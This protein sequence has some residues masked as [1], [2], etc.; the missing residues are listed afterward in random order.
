MI[1]PRDEVIRAGLG[2][3]GGRLA[4]AGASG[5]DATIVHDFS[6]CLNA[7]GPA[8]GVRRAVAESAVEE[9]PDP[10]SRAA[11]RAASA[12]WGR[13][14]EEIML[15]AGAAE[16]IYAVCGAYLRPHDT[17]VVATPAFGDYARATQLCGAT[18]RTIAAGDDDLNE[19]M[20]SVLQIRPRLLFVATPMN[21]TGATFGVETVARLA[22]A[23]RRCD[24]LLV[25][26]QAYDA[27]T[28]QPLGTPAL[29][30]HPNVLH[31]RSLT[32]EH[33]LAGVRVAFGVGPA[34]VV[35]AIERARVPWAASTAA[36]AAAIAALTDEAL[37]HVARTAR[38]LRGEAVR[39][40]AALDAQGMETRHHDTHYLLV[41]CADARATRQRLLDSA[42]I[43]VRDCT[44]FGLPEWIRVAARTP[45]ENDLL[46]EALCRL[47]TTE[48]CM[49]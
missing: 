10:R 26:D 16:L 29:P 15:G 46:I 2:E 17:V 30:G 48:P 25:L 32:K 6:V 40:T 14:I 41:R 12:R 20:A 47:H 21:P 4:L 8:D 33:A 24:T 43:L 49:T 37:R 28:A 7:F 13:P 45:W 18:V 27:F 19:V 38:E 42:S 44:S 35:D 3:H 22:D 11:R 23:C 34:S 1:T 31:L 5:D 9:Y 36:Q 39:I